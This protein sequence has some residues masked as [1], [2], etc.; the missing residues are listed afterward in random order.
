MLPAPWAADRSCSSPTPASSAGPSACCSTAPRGWARPGARRVP[1]GPAG[2]GRPRRRAR[3]RAD[4]Q[5]L[6][7]DA[8]R[9]RRRRRAGSAGSRSTPRGWRAAT[10]RRCSLPG[11]RAPC[12][13]PPRRRS[14]ARRWLAVHHDLLPSAGVAAAVR[15]ATLR[16]DGA[17]ATSEAVARDLRRGGV[18]I[19]HP[20]VD[21][22]AWPA[23]PAGDGPAAR[24][25]AR[26]AGRRGSAPSWR[27]RSPRRVPELELELA[28][29]PL[30][31]DGDGF[32]ARAARARRRGP[33]SPAA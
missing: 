17:V 19:L 10:G 9:A 3:G 6:A 1:G 2:R 15:A 4:P 14:P 8:R 24:A 21:L 29:A 18:T 22:A 23:L 31:G 5:P 16:A 28:G 25:R 11:A 33:T 12:S 26:R 30:P 13:P 20:G 7:A 27:S 32:A